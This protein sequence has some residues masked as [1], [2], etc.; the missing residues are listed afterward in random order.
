MTKKISL[1]V[2]LKKLGSMMTKVKD[3]AAFCFTQEMPGSFLALQSIICQSKSK[4][5][6]ASV[7][8]Y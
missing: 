3:S 8:K 7:Q 5:N 1:H 2:F 6:E 4:N